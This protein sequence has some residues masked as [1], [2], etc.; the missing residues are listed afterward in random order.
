MALCHS[1]RA[2]HSY[3][4]ERILPQLTVLGSAVARHINTF[5]KLFPFYLTKIPLNSTFEFRGPLD[6]YFSP[7]KQ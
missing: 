4:L 7:F 6:S 2:S 5:V 3:W 1:Q